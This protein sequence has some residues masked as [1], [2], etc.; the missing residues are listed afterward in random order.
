VRG[1]ACPPGGAHGH[2]TAAQLSLTDGDVLD[3]RLKLVDEGDQARAG[4]GG[5]P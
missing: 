3:E 1:W 4:P 2:Q 5:Q